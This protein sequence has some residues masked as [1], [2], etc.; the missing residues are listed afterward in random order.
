MA[1]CL[2]RAILRYVS[3][4]FRFRCERDAPLTSSER[5]EFDAALS[6]AGVVSG[7][8]LVADDPAEVGTVASGGAS[9]PRDEDDLAVAL[10]GWLFQL[11]HLLEQFEGT[12]TVRLD[13]FIIPWDPDAGDFDTAAMYP[14]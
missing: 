3:M 10:H 4:S 1:D 9:A 14:G 13:E 11:A 8:P 2:T 5:E 12:W 6:A 7:R